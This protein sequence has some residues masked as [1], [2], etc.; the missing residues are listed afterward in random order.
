MPY[1]G[2]LTPS[3][4]KAAPATAAATAAAPAAPA[5]TSMASK[6][7]NGARPEVGYDSEVNEWSELLTNEQVRFF[8]REKEIRKLFLKIFPVAKD[9]P[10]YW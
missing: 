1:F 4:K 10:R 9:A 2:F 5:P 3:A 8:G 6:T 7:G